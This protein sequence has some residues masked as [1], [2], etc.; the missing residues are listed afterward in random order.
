MYKYNLEVRVVL[1]NIHSILRLI[2]TFY[3]WYSK[4]CRAIS[5]HSASCFSKMSLP[6]L[7]VNIS[8]IIFASISDVRALILLAF[9][10]ILFISRS[11]SFGVTK[12]ISLKGS[13]ESITFFVVIKLIIISPPM[14]F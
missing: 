2:E 10:T 13:H 5:K 8:I 9:S 12:S 3:F 7:L 1:I 4:T 6:K 14:D 11:Y